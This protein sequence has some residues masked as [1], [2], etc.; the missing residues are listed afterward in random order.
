[1]IKYIINKAGNISLPSIIGRGWGWVLFFLFSFSSIAAQ[2]KIINPDITYAGSPRTCTI[3]G[4]NVSGIE[5]YEDYVLTGISGLSVGD[6]IELPGAKI[7]EAVKRYWKHGLFSNVAI[8]ADSLIGDKVYLHI[9]LTVRPRVSTIN[10]I[11]L[12]KSEREDMEQKLGLLK[13][14]Q[15]T[16]NMI[17][18][19]KI[20]A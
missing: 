19:A 4:L 18:R 6:E 1:M 17:D 13:G 8:T 14:N 2:E 10:Y 3:A 5:G 16:P 11:G 12:K 20:L 7:T 15:I 9:H